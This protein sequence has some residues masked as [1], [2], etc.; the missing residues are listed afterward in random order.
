[1]S[2]P[3]DTHRNIVYAVINKEIEG[4]TSA[5]VGGPVRNVFSY[6]VERRLPC[7]E[8]GTQASCVR[9]VVKQVPRFD[10]MRAASRSLLGFDFVAALG[11][12]PTAH[13]EFVNTFIT[14]TH[15][16]TLL[17]VRYT[18]EKRWSVGDVPP[19]VDLG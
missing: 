3:L 2:T 13:L 4:D 18:K 11:A 7:E 15:P 10:D 16:E 5:A 1:M 6:S 17:P 14:D 9:V 12:P 19:I 8:A